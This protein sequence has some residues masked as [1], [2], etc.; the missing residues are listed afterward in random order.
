MV[1]RHTLLDQFSQEGH[2][3]ASKYKS[4]LKTK[5]NASKMTA[6][7]LY[8]YLHTRFSINVNCTSNH[9]LLMAT[10]DIQKPSNHTGS[11]K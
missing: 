2:Y 1:P 11:Q 9:G 6:M 7:A 5:Q 8:Q 4:P 10:H 3:N